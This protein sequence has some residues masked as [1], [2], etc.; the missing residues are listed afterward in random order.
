MTQKR[1]ELMPYLSISLL[2]GRKA[3][4]G[5]VRTPSRPGPLRSGRALL[6]R[7]RVEVDVEAV[8]VVDAVTA[9]VAVAANRDPVVGPYSSTA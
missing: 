3:G 6:R 4:C 9:V 5:S 8:D 2:L 7:V 1:E